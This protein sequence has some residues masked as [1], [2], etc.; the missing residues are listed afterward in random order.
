[1]LI[2]LLTILYIFVLIIGIVRLTLIYLNQDCK[3]KLD[4]IPFP[5]FGL[6]MKTDIVGLSCTTILFIIWRL[7]V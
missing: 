2:V 1:M 6:S 3:E 7:L 4:F 5:E